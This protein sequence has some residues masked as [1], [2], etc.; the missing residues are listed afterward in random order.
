MTIWNPLR[1]QVNSIPWIPLKC[2]EIDL[3]TGLSFPSSPDD[4]VDHPDHGS[5]IPL[6]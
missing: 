1:V 2:G 6:G 3:A 5:L 4:R